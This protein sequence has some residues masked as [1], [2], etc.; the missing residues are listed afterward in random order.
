LNEI[1][2]KWNKAQIQL[3]LEMDKNIILK[4][5]KWQVESGAETEIILSIIE[6]T[7]GDKPIIPIMVIMKQIDKMLIMKQIPKEINTS[8]A[9][10][11]KIALE[12]GKYISSNGKTIKRK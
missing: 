2:I 12:S 8:E 11:L 1:D 4:N 6:K 9:G 3:F 10:I 5:N 7:I